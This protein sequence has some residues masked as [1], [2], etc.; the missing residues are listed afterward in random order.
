[1]TILALEFSSA[2]R[3][4][5]VAHGDSIFE[6]VESGGR[7]TAAFSM[8]EKVL[9]EAKIERE[10]IDAIAVG[11]GPGSYTGIRSAIAIAQGWQ[12]VREIKLIGVGSV[13]AITTQ[14]R[15][16]KIFGRVN[17]AV[18]AQRGEIYLARFEISE[19]AAVEVEPLKILSPAQIQIGAEELF[20]G[21]EVTKWFPSGRT[22]FPQ[23]SAIA[24]L[25]VE[26]SN[27]IDGQNL[28]PIYLRETNF[29]KA[30]PSRIIV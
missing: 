20:A 8:I 15:A 10:K 16:E 18:D 27:F 5:A 25:A 24:K 14:A 3:S 28:E 9:A 6:T 17:V 7:G 29:I 13:E 22:I 4:V 12:L 11:L 2:Q 1:M 23:A 19:R 21:P 26:K 30:P